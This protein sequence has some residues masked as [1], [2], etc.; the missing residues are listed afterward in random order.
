MVPALPP[1]FTAEVCRRRHHSP[2]Q[3]HLIVSRFRADIGLGRSS[4][5]IAWHPGC[6]SFEAQAV[7]GGATGL[8]AS[9]S[10]S[11]RPRT[12]RCLTPALAVEL[13]HVVGDGLS[14][15]AATN[16]ELA[17]VMALT[18]V[19]AMPMIRSSLRP[20]PQRPDHFHRD[21]DRA[22]CGLLVARHQHRG[23]GLPTVRPPR[24]CSG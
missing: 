6:S 20:P 4:T 19:L 21:A 14:I 24:I 2:K 9:P 7:G 10:P 17:H 1:T 12:P 8:K 18:R 13:P 5:V 23:R 3:P 11:S 15:K 22:G 16:R